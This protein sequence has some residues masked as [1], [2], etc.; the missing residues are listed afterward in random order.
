MESEEM[1]VL[2]FC[3]NNDW[4]TRQHPGNT[5]EDPRTGVAMG[6]QKRL[7]V[8]IKRCGWSQGQL[9]SIPRRTQ[10]PPFPWCFS[11]HARF[12]VVDTCL[13]YAE[14]LGRR[15]LWPEEPRGTLETCTGRP[16][17]RL[18]D[19][20]WKPHLDNN[21]LPLDPTNPSAALYCF[22]WIFQGVAGYTLLWPTKVSF[23]FNNVY[24]EPEK[25]GG[26]GPGV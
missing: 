19:P 5:S 6:V 11:P 26:Q 7:S 1:Q 9:E 14:G 4:G 23:E 22:S 20:E 10:D 12:W 21:S 25:G 15:W 17:L 16:V 2:G 13:Q 8:L 24:A 3:L 18:Q